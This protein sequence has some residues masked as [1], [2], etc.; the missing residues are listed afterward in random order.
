M[1]SKLEQKAESLE[2]T[3][4]KY[5]RRENLDD[6]V[7]KARGELKEYNRELRQLNERLEDL[8]HFSTVLSDVFGEDVPE[9]VVTVGQE[10]S[11][12]TNRRQQ[13]ILELLD[14]EKLSGKRREVRNLQDKVKAAADDVKSELEDVGSKWQK[15]VSTAESVL[16]IAGG[17]RSFESTLSDIKD[18]V[19]QEIWKTSKRITTLDSR[20]QGLEKAWEKEAVDWDSFQHEHSLEN[21]TIDILKE[22]S[23]GK[24]VHIGNVSMD[25]L[26][27][28]NRV[29]QLGNNIDLTI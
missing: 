1:S 22:L 8:A 2:L 9:S 16:K 17:S 29:S 5:E 7:K 4:R 21:E 27:D 15:R 20:W 11:E 24:S 19:N 3:V 26:E 10:V 14:K 28:M 12:V 18:F 25:V 6:Q 23:R 13:D